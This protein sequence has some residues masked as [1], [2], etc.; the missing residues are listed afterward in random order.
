MKKVYFWGLISIAIFFYWLPVSFAE[1]ITI[2]IH[3]W[4][5]Y[6]KPYTGQFLELVKKKYKKD[7]R[8]V[9][10]NVSNP[11]EFWDVSRRSKADLISPA[12]NILKSRNGVFINKGI[13]LPVNLK[14]IPNYKFLLPILQRN[15]FVTE[16]GK[17][18]GVPYTMG[19]YGLAYN[20]KK[21]KK[22]ES[23]QV[24]WNEKNKKTY[25]ISQDYPD[26]NI[27]ITALVLG[28]DYNVLY[29]YNKLMKQIPLLEFQK[30]LNMLSINSFSMW[31][32]TADYKEFPSLSYA[33]TWGYAVVKANKNGGDWKM[34]T[35]IEG[36]TMWIDH[37]VITQSVKDNLL[38]KVLCEEWINYCLSPN[39]QVGAIRNWGVSPVVSNIENLLTEDE[40]Q[41]FKVGDIQ[42]WKTLS[43]W[44]NQ[45]FDTVYGYKN[46]WGRALNIQ[47]KIQY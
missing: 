36:S 43:L 35:P 23:W 9:I 18:Y 34:A 16:N 10:T 30:K 1:H 13:V 25:T 14:N 39:L 17:I 22:P 21:V 40:I 5:G 37:W 15:K 31:K 20:S 2:R 38:K 11:E 41:I 46:L 32:G 26:C 12:H 7:I 28:A 29:N 42:Y 47:K 4:K 6:S 24:L 27:Y 8:L 3:C 45:G 33:A 44:E 19:S